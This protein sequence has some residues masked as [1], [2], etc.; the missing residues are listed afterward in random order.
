MTG[1][2]SSLVS[3]EFVVGNVGIGVGREVR[4]ILL[5]LIPLDCSFHNF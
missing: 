5:L 3:D 4:G 1:S 2:V